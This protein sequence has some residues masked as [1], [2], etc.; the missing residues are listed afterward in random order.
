MNKLYLEILYVI[1][2]YVLVLSVFY[3]FKRVFKG[4]RTVNII[5][6]DYKNFKLSFN[7]VIYGFATVAIL[8]SV[9]VLSIVM[10]DIIKF[11]NTTIYAISFFILI[12][13]VSLFYLLNSRI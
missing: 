9:T 10:I 7:Y 13:F 8:T 12:I 5:D 3:M 1:I 6:Q 4:K 2:I 11:D